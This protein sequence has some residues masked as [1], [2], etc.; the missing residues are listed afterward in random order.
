MRW[1]MT[2]FG[3]IAMEFE[4]WIGFLRLM[5]SLRRGVEITNVRF[6]GTGT[7]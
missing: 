3:T 7:R 6:Q 1:V 4:N 5:L 2:M